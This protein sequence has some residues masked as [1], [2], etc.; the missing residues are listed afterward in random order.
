MAPV[1]ARTDDRD[2]LNPSAPK[3]EAAESG[4]KP[5]TASEGDWG[6]SAPPRITSGET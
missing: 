4:A 6:K 5:G 2:P 3:K 1:I